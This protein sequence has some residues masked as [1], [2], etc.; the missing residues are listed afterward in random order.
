MSCLPDLFIPTK[1]QRL[2]PLNKV[3]GVF[4][5]NLRSSYFSTLRKSGSLGETN[6][7][8]KALSFSL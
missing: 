4:S 7:N 5:V 2:A 1:S 8:D 3:G 6:S